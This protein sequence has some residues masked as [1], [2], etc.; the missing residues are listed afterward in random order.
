MTLKF[1]V[2]E[3]MDGYTLHID[4]E[5]VNAEVGA[6]EAELRRLMVDLLAEVGDEVEQ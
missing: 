1:D 4:T 3:G 6:T 2:R 5:Q